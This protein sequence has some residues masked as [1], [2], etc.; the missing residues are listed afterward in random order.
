MRYGWRARI[1]QIRPSSAIESQEEWRSVAPSGVAFIDARIHVQS[2]TEAG[3]DEM[4]DQVV[5]EARK[6]ATAMPD[7]IIQ[8]STPGVFQRGYGHE[9]VVVQEIESA[10]GVRATTM[11]SAIVEALRTLEI[12]RLAV[13]T[14][15]IDSI[16]EKLVAYL[17]AAGF[18]VSAI[19]GLQILVPQDCI[20][21]EPDASYR[22]AREVV[23]AS[24]GA[25]G[26]LFCSALRTF[27]VI[28]ALESDTGMPVVTSNQAA[29]WH[30]L[31]SCA[32]PD[33]LP[34]LGRLL[35]HH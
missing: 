12:R 15:Y 31:R 25:D 2:L 30:A 13:A 28:D 35:A 24:S 17:E 18:E 6:V 10:T 11:M 14:L 32:I 4:M 23:A 1:G 19:K 3:H 8:C 5:S 21:I 29:L 16:N 22:F 20:D 34:G 33:R 26:V 9:R 7:L 27:E